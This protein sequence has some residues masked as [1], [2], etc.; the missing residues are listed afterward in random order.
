MK[1]DANKALECSLEV[2][3]KDIV[4]VF[5]LIRQTA[6]LPSAT[7]TL[8]QSFMLKSIMVMVKIT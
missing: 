5:Q 8:L 3:F 1:V 6:H 7:A 4:T 2:S